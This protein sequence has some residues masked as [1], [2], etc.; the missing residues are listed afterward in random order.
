MMATCAITM[1]VVCRGDEL[2]I[3][4]VIERPAP[5]VE[6][7]GAPP[8]DYLPQP[9]PTPHEQVVESA[10]QFLQARFGTKV[11]ALQPPP[12]VHLITVSTGQ[13]PLQLCRIHR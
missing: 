4:H 13:V 9:A 2:N 5:Q 8:V 6:H 3:V 1:L 12:V 7:Y 11:Q 10:K